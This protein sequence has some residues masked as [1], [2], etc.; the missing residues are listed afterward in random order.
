MIGG[1]NELGLALTMTL[2]LLFYMRQRYREYRLQWPLLG[3]IGFTVVACLFTYSRG[4]LL[5]MGAMAGIAWLRSRRKLGAAVLAVALAAG[6]WAFAPPQW[7]GRME[8]IQTYQLDQSAELRL[9]LWR[10]SWAMALKHPV[11]GGG[12]RWSYNLPEVARELSGEG[13]HWSDETSGGNDDT[14][15]GRLP[16]L[17]KPRV[18]HSIWFEMVSDHGFPGL[19]LF[20]G[21]LLCGVINAGWLIRHARGSP[22]LAWASDL[23]AMLRA[24]LVAYAVGGSFASMNF[25]DLPYVIVVVAAAARRVV[26]RVIA[27]ETNSAERG[28]TRSVASTRPPL[29]SQPV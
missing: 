16:P 2:P 12:F 23:G 21:V 18:A 10:L 22:D 26:L 28:A 8:T 25:Y 9:Y 13:F 15:E 20:I 24:S 17:V 11:F 5:A 3:L 14:S 19:F 4:A 1:N 7:F 6:V 29:H 27:A